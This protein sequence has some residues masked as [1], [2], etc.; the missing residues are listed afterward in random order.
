MN[1]NEIDSLM[2]TIELTLRKELPRYHYTL[3]HWYELRRIMED[4]F[5]EAD[6]KEFVSSQ[7][8]KQAERAEEAALKMQAMEELGVDNWEGYDLAM[9]RFDE[10]NQ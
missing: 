7:W 1:K 8:V 6:G 10:L 9:Q 5:K 3:V 4:H 2:D